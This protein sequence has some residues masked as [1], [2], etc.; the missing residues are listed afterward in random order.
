MGDQF[1][2]QQQVLVPTDTSAFGYSVSSPQADSPTAHREG[3]MQAPGPGSTIYGW[4]SS[5]DSHQVG[6]PYDMHFQTG[7]VVSSPVYHNHSLK[8]ATSGSTVNTPD[9]V[10]EFGNAA[11]T[12]ERGT[13]NE[14]STR[15]EELSKRN[16]SI[17]F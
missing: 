6:S 9:R 3:D 14:Q 12:S 2:I 7:G 1:I 5:E 15:A 4:Q 11:L 16:P 17:Y 8:D 10:P 13:E